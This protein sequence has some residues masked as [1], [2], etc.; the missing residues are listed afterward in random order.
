MRFILCLSALAVS[1]VCLFTV[2]VQ[3]AGASES[4]PTSS[5]VT[6]PTIEVRD[7]QTLM[8]DAGRRYALALKNE[9]R[10]RNR[11]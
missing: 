2:P 6:V 8:A 10:V 9:R 7:L 1:I 3:S 5:Q 4:L 11:K